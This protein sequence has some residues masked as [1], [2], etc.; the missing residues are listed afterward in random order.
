MR[1]GSFSILRPVWIYVIILA[2]RPKN[3]SSLETNQH[4]D[5]LTINAWI[6]SANEAAAIK[7]EILSLAIQR[8]SNGDI[9]MSWKPLEIAG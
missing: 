2:N 6:E 3:K 4:M 7:E 5:P 9:I 1:N 8:F